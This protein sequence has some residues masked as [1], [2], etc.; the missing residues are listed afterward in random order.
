M[1][2]KDIVAKLKEESIEVNEEDIYFKVCSCMRDCIGS[3]MYLLTRNGT[4]W[5]CMYRATRIDCSF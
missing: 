4:S 2:V 5:A 1:S 3:S